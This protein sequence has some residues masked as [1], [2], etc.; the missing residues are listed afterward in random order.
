MNLA[1][2]GK[3]GDLKSKILAFLPKAASPV[4]FVSPPPS[5][6][7]PNAGRGFSGPM[8]SLIPKEARRKA[9]S[10]SV[11]AREP[12]SPKVS[13]MGQVKNKKNKKKKKTNPDENMLVCCPKSLMKVL[14]VKQQSDS[15]SDTP[16][17]RRPVA[18][19]APSLGHMKQ[20]ASGRGVL[21]RF[22][23]KAHDIAKTEDGQSYCADDKNDEDRE[24]VIVANSE[25]KVVDGEILL[26]P[27]KEVNLWMRRTMAPPTPLKL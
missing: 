15:K 26:E 17:E 14:N 5:P 7:R 3:Q 19:R 27:R 18:E 16:D 21:H 12:T 4:T 6:V 20:F 13:C 22:D 9:R 25:A 11:D 24:K 8:V 1:L 10:G 23:W 2:M